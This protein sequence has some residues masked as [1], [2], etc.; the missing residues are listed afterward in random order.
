MNFRYCIFLILLLV[1]S[2]SHS[3]PIWSGYRASL[4]ET[5]YMRMPFDL[6]DG[7]ATARVQLTASG[8][9]TLWVNGKQVY[10][11]TETQVEPRTIFVT[12]YL[13]DGKNVLAIKCEQ[14]SGQG[15]IAI[16]LGIQL[17]DGRTFRA[18]SDNKVRTSHRLHVGWQSPGFDD[19]SWGNAIVVGISAP[20]LKP[21]APIVKLN[22]SPLPVGGK[23]LPTAH[24]VIVK[25]DYTRLVRVWDYQK[26]E[27]NSVR[28]YS[29]E[30]ITGERMLL[31]AEY[32]S[33]QDDLPVLASAGF[34]LILHEADARHPEQVSAGS[35]SFRTAEAEY[36]Q[37]RLSGLDWAY[38]IQTAFPPDWV[39]RQKPNQTLRSLNTNLM[40]RAFS[41]WDPRQTSY[42]TQLAAQLST[43]Y[44]TR[45]SGLVYT[46]T[47]DLSARLDWWC[48]DSLARADFKL[49]MMKKYGS[50]GE[51]NAAWHTNY[52]QEQDIV[53]PIGPDTGSRRRWL[54]FVNWYSQSFCYAN[55]NLSRILRKSLPETMLIQAI[56]GEE[57][58]RTGLDAS[59]AAKLAAKRRVGI[60]IEETKS[61]VETSMLLRR[62]AS[63][64]R[65]YGAPFWMMPTGEVTPAGETAR[66]FAA[67]SLG[68]RG[69]FDRPD[70]VHKSAEAY[71]RNG[72]YLKI[73]TPINDV[74]M[75]YP[76]TSRALRLNAA[77]VRPFESGCM[78]LRDVMN[79]DILDER[80]ITDGALEHFRV[81]VMWEGM[82]VEAD[83][84][85]KIQDWVQRGG[86]ICSYDYGKVETVEGDRSWFADLFGYAGKLAPT[87]S[88]EAPQIGI[89]AEFDIQRLRTQWARPYGLG[90]TVFFP[91]QRGQLNA[92]Y[93]VI[94]YLTY[95]LS[96]LDS[97]KADG[98]T[99]D[100][101]FDG[102]FST[103][104]EDKIL[105][106]NPSDKSI[107]RTVNLSA[108]AL[109]SIPRIEPPAI[110]KHTI[111]VEPDSIYALY[112]DGAPQELLLQCEKFTLLNGL[113]PAAG[114][115]YSPGQGLT[116]VAVPVRGAITTRFQC[117]VP[118]NYRVL[119]RTI[120]NGKL[121][122][123]EIN[124]DGEMIKPV[125]AR[126][127]QTEL[128]TFNAG[129]IS[130]TKGVHTLTLKPLRGAALKADF[131]LLCTDQTIAGY[132][133]AVQRK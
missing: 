96:E 75:F 45:A 129:Q 25:Y 131:V 123:A 87:F 59:L 19:S 122:G 12:R 13:Q 116:H 84:L 68:S 11:T 30:R 24:P 90:W 92:Y 9:S 73:S 124:I 49:Q 85:N 41:P 35:W 52:I 44:N 51:L 42:A 121:A 113:V 28:A 15:S 91:V 50:L 67:A 47:P 40:Y 55:D 17:S 60:R 79:Y 114:S 33:K 80:M 21:G 43:R 108:K 72:K 100:D 117:E 8:S 36:Q 125:A 88:P 54:D 82:V 37:I 22:V 58:L 130:L 10:R 74:A 103:L 77:G 7:A 57:D 105:Y 38:G 115:A 61:S 23:P 71:Y 128:Q 93:Q 6:S 83:V 31:A 86:V 106:Y 29:K 110:L 48:A 95:H 53:Y 89:G 62:I 107:T 69:I 26:G 46:A 126:L 111:T 133:F 98:V 102:L 66:I 20:V 3:A 97:A 120:N 18:A 127:V 76:T 70:N 118:G 63:A 56:P 4:P 5:V 1:V 81:L 109:Q 27:N 104:L 78:D 119:Y 2:R 34:S 132:S 101:A 39:I 99:S 112:F 64:C 32:P 65:F 94:R 14:K 16:D